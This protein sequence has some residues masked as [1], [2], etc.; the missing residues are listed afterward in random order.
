[1]KLRTMTPTVPMTNADPAR[2]AKLGDAGASDCVGFC[3]SGGG[4]S[5]DI[6]CRYSYVFV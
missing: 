6:M 1:V 3:D 5:E 4:D 2:H